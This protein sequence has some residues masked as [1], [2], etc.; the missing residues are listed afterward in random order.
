[1]LLPT[2]V[3]IFKLKHYGLF[4]SIQADIRSLKASAEDTVEEAL[5]NY[6]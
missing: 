3:T 5:P 6:L 4:V 1:M 2:L